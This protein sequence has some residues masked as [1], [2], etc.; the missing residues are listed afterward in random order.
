MASA[1][2][3]SPKVEFI[4][5]AVRLLVPCLAASIAAGGCRD[6]QRLSPPGQLAS[7]YEIEAGRGRLFGFIPLA[8]AAVPRGLRFTGTNGSENGSLQWWPMAPW[9]TTRYRLAKWSRQLDTVNAYIST[10]HH[11]IRFRFRLHGDSLLGSVESFS[12]FD[13]PPHAPATVVGYPVS[14]P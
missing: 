7:C 6:E 5:A 11:G 8:H 3:K 9:D 2:L 4:S 14:C 1:T 13:F 12:D 10:G